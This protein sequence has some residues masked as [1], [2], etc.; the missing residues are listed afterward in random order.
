ML[1]AWFAHSGQGGKN[2][3]EK[4]AKP[5]Q[6]QGMKSKNVKQVRFALPL[7]LQLIDGIALRRSAAAIKSR[8][9]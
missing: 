7:L 9:R 5:I 8:W 6:V 1:I 2:P 3:R 4:T